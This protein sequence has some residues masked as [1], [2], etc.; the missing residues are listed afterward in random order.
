MVTEAGIKN[1]ITNA[2]L[3]SHSNEWEHE[4]EFQYI[5]DEMI[6]YL[7]NQGVNVTRNNLG[8]GKGLRAYY[9]A[10]A[11]MASTINDHAT[12]KKY[13]DLAGQLPLEE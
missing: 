6:A 2:T 8:T 1:T 9:V 12:E 13:R 3:I 11:E 4:R 5:V 10:R 7:R